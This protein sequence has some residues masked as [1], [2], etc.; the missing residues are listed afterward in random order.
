M[1][2]AAMLENIYGHDKSTGNRS[3]LAALESL[4]GQA[5]PAYA[6]NYMS[7]VAQAMTA[8]R[9]GGQ[10]PVPKVPTGELGIG[11]IGIPGLTSCS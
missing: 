7:P 9:Y 4:S 5:S 8:R 6:Q 2:L 1:N 11:G 10:V 3:R